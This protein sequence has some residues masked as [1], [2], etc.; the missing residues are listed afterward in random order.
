MV[1]VLLFLLLEQ[2]VLF[3]RIRFAFRIRG[4][5]RRFQDP[6]CLNFFFDRLIIRHK[7]RDRFWRHHAVD[8]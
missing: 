6:I 1:M 4:S 7:T 3:S 2:L 8:R 5:R